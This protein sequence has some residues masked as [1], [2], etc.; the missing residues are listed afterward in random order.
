MLKQVI[1]HK[2]TFY[3][4]VIIATLVGLRYLKNDRGICLSFITLFYLLS[5]KYLTKNKAISLLLAIV[6]LHFSC[7]LFVL[8]GKE[9]RRVTF[10]PDTKKE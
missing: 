2:Y 7:S 6:V 3:F 5:N 10:S 1:E 8:L 9:Q 4:M